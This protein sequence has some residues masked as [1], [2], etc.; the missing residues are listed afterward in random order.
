MKKI[1]VLIA[2]DQVMFAESLKYVLTHAAPDIDVVGI[3]ENGKQALELA[4]ALEIDIVLMDVRMPEMDGVESVR[5]IHQHKN[6]IRV[7]MLTTFDDDD[8][9]YYAVKYGAVGYILKNMPPD[10]LVNA[11]RSIM[12]GATLFSRTIREKLQHAPDSGQNHSFSPL[13]PREREVVAL[14]LDAL[15][16]KQIADSLGIGM[17]VVRNYTSSIYGKLH[18]DNR[19]DLIHKFKNRKP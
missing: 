14:L 9:V 18:V 3:A 1:R 19:L 16:N 7:V 13:T 17:Q 12:S 5:L 11:I 8:Y 2:D 6:D 4:L 10:G 15:S